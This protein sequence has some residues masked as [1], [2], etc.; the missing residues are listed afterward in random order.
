MSPSEIPDMHKVA[1]YNLHV[2]SKLERVT[3]KKWQASLLKEN[4]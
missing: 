3:S 2:T 4:A 1:K